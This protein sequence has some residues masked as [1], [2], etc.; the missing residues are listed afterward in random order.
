MHPLGEIR[1]KK[2]YLIFQMLFM[3]H[4]FLWVCG[5]FLSGEYMFWG[6]LWFLSETGKIVPPWVY[7]LLAAF[8]VSHYNALTICCNESQSQWPATPVESLYSSICDDWRNNRPTVC[9]LHCVASGYHKLASSCSQFSPFAFKTSFTSTLQLVFWTDTERKQSL[10]I[11][12]YAL[13]SSYT[14]IYT[15]RS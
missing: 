6:Q 11:S 4:C 8:T 7:S 14:N 13:S 10:H 2:N 15:C 5:A 12:I 3:T 1:G 9:L